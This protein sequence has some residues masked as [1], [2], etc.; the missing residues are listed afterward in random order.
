MHDDDQ[1]H[2]DDERI[3]RLLDDEL[4][5]ALRAVAESHLRTCA[6]CRAHLDAARAEDAWLADR[7]LE[8][9][10]PAIALHS[11]SQANADVT[12]PRPMTH[13]P[14]RDRANLPLRSRSGG[15]VR[16]TV[17]AA[18][19]IL[20]ATLAY[21]MPGSPVPR[22]IDDLFGG[23][24]ERPAPDAPLI[25]ST[26]HSPAS[27]EPPNLTHPTAGMSVKP[28]GAFTVRFE[29][30]Q[31]SGALWVSFHDGADVEVRAARDT[32]SFATSERE[33]TVNNRGRHADYELK[34]PRIPHLIRV[35]IEGRDVLVVREGGVLSGSAPTA[36]PVMRVPLDR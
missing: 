36:G 6:A 32:V 12:R 29:S 1:R 30:R 23:R 16:A 26:P 10:A 27:E 18:A 24:R 21:T 35:Q 19:L 31:A 20:V 9:D 14:L 28:A 33:L 8:L 11:A 34:L 17:G 5:P 22:W 15:W 13:R 3:Q 2:L 25:E 7:L 4:S